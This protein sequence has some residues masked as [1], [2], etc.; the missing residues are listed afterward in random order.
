MNTQAA[1]GQG[2]VSILDTPN[3]ENNSIITGGTSSLGN[4]TGMANGDNGKVSVSYRGMENP[5]GN[6]WKFVYGVNIWGDGTKKGGVPY[7]CTDFNYAESKN[8]E[9]YESAGFTL[10]NENG[11]ISA[12]GYSEAF[13]WLFMPSETVGNSSLPVGDYL[14]ITPNLNGYKIAPLGGSWGVG[15]GAGAFCWRLGIGVGL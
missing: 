5:W 11:Y 4:N 14:Y 8:S 6:I 1:I 10:S 2:V 7:I 9:N 3:T 13:D 15:S 12:M